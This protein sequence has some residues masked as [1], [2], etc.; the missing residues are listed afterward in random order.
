MT[1]GM[2]R[3]TTVKAAVGA[4]GALALSVPAL[5]GAAQAVVTSDES[6]DPIAGQAPSEVPAPQ[7]WYSTPAAG[8]ERESLPIGGGALG[9]S[10]FGTLAT[11]R[12]TLNEKTLWTGGPGSVQGY[13]FG[14]WTTAGPDALTGVREDLDRAGVL[15][16]DEVAAALGQARRGY[17]AYQ[18]LGDLLIRL[19]DA[20]AA[21]DGSCRRALDLS[22]ALATVAHTHRKAHHNSG[23]PTC[24]PTRVTARSSSPRAGPRGRC[25]GCGPGAASPSTSNGPRV[26]PA[27]SSSR[28][29]APAG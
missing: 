6:S 1:S 10:V 12:L 11:E 17:G 8:W 27:V 21:P 15:G 13:D 4:T 7:L 9:A 14:N 20:P 25:G 16:P 24:A 3:R 29:D 2:T 28:R 5:A 19:P 18:V 23:W 26:R 22:T